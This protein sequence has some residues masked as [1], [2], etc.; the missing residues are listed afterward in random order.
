MGT[1]KTGF[2]QTKFII[3]PSE[4]RD[5][6]QLCDKYK[7][8]FFVP[9]YGNPQ[10]TISEVLQEYTTAYEKCTAA[11]KPEGFIRSLA[12]QMTIQ[13]EKYKSSFQLLLDDIQ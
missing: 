10:N 5:F 8:E 11:E 7:F 9:S 3:T 2:W 6:L 13:F 12:Y 1:I 4:F